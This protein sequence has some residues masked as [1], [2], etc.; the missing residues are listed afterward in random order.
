MTAP[1]DVR[2][3][4]DLVGPSNRWALAA[5]AV[6]MTLALATTGHRRG[7]GVLGAE[8][9]NLERLQTSR[10]LDGLA[11]SLHNLP[12]AWIINNLSVDSQSSHASEGS[13]SGSP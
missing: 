9:G 10:H 5:T 3:V 6:T 7:G 13:W 4:L 2:D 1:G 8:R 11:S 12:L